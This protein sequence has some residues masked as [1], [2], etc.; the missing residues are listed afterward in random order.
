MR[1]S[2]N[3]VMI[4]LLTVMMVLG[5]GM[6][7]FRGSGKAY[8]A[9]AGDFSG[10]G[11]SGTPY[12]VGTA[13]QLNKIRGSYLG[14]GLY[15]KLN[16]DIDL[17]GYSHWAPIGD[18]N[19][20]FQGHMDG[21]GHTITGLT[22]NRPD[23]DYSGLFGYIDTDSTVSGMKLEQ[24]SVKGWQFTGGL[25]GYN[26]GGSISSSY[27][28]GNVSGMY[29]V[30]GLLGYNAGG[31]ID[32][33]HALGTVTG[34]DNSVQLG[35]LVGNSTGSAWE[36]SNSY[37]SV[38]VKGGRNS[39]EVGG[40]A[41]GVSDG[42]I[43]NSYALG[44]VSGGR[45]SKNVGGLVGVNDS[46][47]IISSYA[48]GHVSG[49][50][51]VGGLVGNE[52]TGEEITDSYATGNVSGEEHVGG[53]IGR[54]LRGTIRGG[55]ASGEV[56]GSNSSNL[57]GGL[58]GENLFGKIS[59]SQA[60]GA[61]LSGQGS[62]YVGGLTGRNE[63]AEI[64]NSP[65]SGEVN[66]FMYVGGLV[67]HDQ[68]GAISYSHASGHVKGEDG[69]LYIGGLVGYHQ[70]ALIS[71]SYALG[72]VSA[73]GDSFSIGGLVGDN[74][75]EI[76][77]SYASGKVSGAHF[78]GGLVGYTNDQPIST[79][80]ASGDVSGVEGVGGLVGYHMFNAISNSYASGKVSG[81]DGSTQVGG[82]I[83]ITAYGNIS[84]SYVSGKVS[85]SSNVGGFIGEDIYALTVNS[86]YDT[87]TT[88]QPGTGSGTGKVTA[89][90]QDQSTY[91][92]DMAH[93][94]DF[95][96]TWAI[97]ARHNG[98]Y[99]YL[100][101]IQAY[102]D[103]D[104]NKHTGGTAPANHSYMPGTKAGVYSGVLNI[105]KTGY[106][107]DGWNTQADGSGSSYRPGDLYTIT[108]DTTLYAKWKPV[109]T[110]ATLTSTIGTVSTGGTTNE[111]ITGIPYGTTL[112]SLKAAITTAADATFE[113]YEA[114]GTTVAT[115]LTSEQ[116]IIVTA[117]DGT[118][119][120]TYT[121]TVAASS[122]KEITAFSFAE[123]T[124]A[125][126]I[127]ATAHT[128]AVEVAYGTSLNGLVAAFSVSAG[129]LAKVGGVD[130]VSGVTA[131]DFTTPVV[132]VV[133]AA[134]GSTQSWTVTV[135][136][137]ASS[138][139]EITSFSFVEQTG[140][141]VIDAVA[142]TVAIEV[143]HGTSLNGLVATFSVSAGASVKVGGVD[144][145]SGSTANDFTAPVVYV[146]K[147]ADGS[148]QNWAVTVSVAA[149]SAKEITSFSFSEQTGAAVIDAGAQTVAIEVSHGTSLNG[150][151][152][153]F[154]V[155]AGATANV[156]GLDQVSGT[157]A[158][159]FT[160]PVIYVVQAA[161]GSTQSW[162][163]TVSVA[164]S[165]AKEITSFSLAEQT[166]AAVI[167]AFA[168]TVA[169]EVAHETS[170]NG[171]VSTFSVSTGALAKV[172]GVDQVSGTTANDF[173]APVVYVVKAADGSTQSWTVTVSVAASSAKEITS[174]SFVEQTG[175]AVIDAGTHTV[176]IEVA[177]GT[178]LNG[179]VSTFGVSAGASAKVGGV[180]QVSGSTANDFTTQVIYVVKAVDGSTQNWMVTVCV[181]A[182]SA[183]ELTVFSFAEQ[184]GAAVIDAVAHTVA[185]EV[186]H[187]TS[188]NGL[189]STFGLS[190]GASVK[191]G[192][193][194]Q[195]SGATANNFSAPV[196]Y[197]VKAA[198]GSTQNW[199][200]TVSIAA[201]SAKELTSFSFAQQTGAAVIDAVAHTVAIEVAHGTS[202]NSLVSTFSVSAGASAKVGGVDQVSGTTAND[203]T[204][205]VIY[206]VKAADGSMQNW[207]VTVSVA[208]SS[209]KELTAFSFAEQTGAAVIDATTHT[210]TIEVA[211]GTSLNGLVSTFSVSA[212]AS[213]KV[214]TVDQVSGTTANDFTAPVIYVVK[215]ADGST[216]NWTVTVSVA[217]SSSKKITSF[218]FAE[219]TGA[220]VIDA[221][222][223][224][225]AIEVVHGTSL[226]GLVSTFSVSAGASAKVGGVDQVSDTTSNDFTAPVVYVVKA[227]DGSIQNWTVTVSIAM[228][229]AKEIT[230]FSFAE[231]TGAAVIDAVAH[232]VAIE[233]VHGTSLNGLVSTFGLS[234]GASAKV[235]GVD[236]VSG[237]TANDFT[238]PVVYVVKAADGST[239]SW[240]VT[241]TTAAN[242]AKDLTAFSFQGLTPPI[243]GIINGTQIA[244]TVPNGTAVTSLV[245]TFTNSAG[246]TVTVG[247]I[248]QVSGTT[249]NDFTSPLT[250]TVTAQDGTRAS[251]TVVVTQSGVVGGS[252]SLSS[253][254][255][256]GGG[257]PLVADSVTGTTYQYKVSYAISSI[258]VTASAYD[259]HTRIVGSL[260]NSDHVLVTGPFQIT[261]GVGTDPIPL[262]VGGNRL[263]LVLTAVDGSSQT[264][265]VFVNRTSA[266]YSNAHLQSLQVGN[267]DLMFNRDILDYTLSVGNRV[268]T[269]TVK[270]LPEVTHAGVIIDAEPT[271]SKEI[272]LP[273]GSTII[274]I[275]VTAP[276]GITKR[277]YRVT[278]KRAIAITAVTDTSIPVTSDPVTITVPQGVTNAK[279]AVTPVVAGSNKE[280]I[281]PLIEVYAETAQGP[282]TVIIPEGTKVTAPEGWDGM[283]LLPEIQSNES[284]SVSGSRVSGV[285]EIG[286]PDVTLTFD[287]AIRLLFPKQGGKLAGYV[288]NGGVIPITASITSDTQATAD[289]EIAPG[290]E[291]KLT[292]GEDM[293]V[294]TK[295]FTK[296][297]FYLP[298]TPTNT[299]SSGGG[300]G[301]PSNTGIIYAPSGGTLTLNGVHIE[302]PAGAIE[303]DIQVTVD[304]LGDT[305]TMPTG[306][307]LSLVSD[308]FDIKKDTAG[309]FHK[310]VVLT[311]P[312]DKSKV[313][314]TK[315]TVGLY[316]WDEKKRT[317]LPLDDQ[318]VDQTTGKVSGTVRQFTKFAALASDKKV[319]TNPPTEVVDLGDIQ[320][321][322]A[323]TSIRELVKLGVIHGYSDRTFKPNNSITRAEFVTI[324][325]KAFQ[326]QAQTGQTFADTEAHWAR[327]AIE[328][329]A[330]LGVVTG[331][332]ASTFG[333]D[334]LITR[335][336]MAAIIIRAAHIDA[337]ENKGSF[338]DNADISDW[339]RT[340][341]ATAT[342]QALMNGYEDGT[343][344]PQANSTRA[345]AATVILRALQ[346]KKLW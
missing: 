181:A 265:L 75:G 273:V 302:V 343:V 12:L 321:H 269:L 51:R 146:V 2:G 70:N 141:A 246:S 67:G 322:W 26:N 80:F 333:P 227:A 164:A 318:Q 107:F 323:E 99:P 197:V 184:T 134:D 110:I 123:Q 266:A 52:S 50:T 169:I 101:A 81:D 142:H 161:N 57:V 103:Y 196:V 63:S 342:A 113:I 126:V 77:A 121:V 283:I 106:V 190:A 327:S 346:L 5:T 218:S 128:V 341:L 158:N 13:D 156:G 250:Y 172:G 64:S 262:A 199:T 139:K 124:G 315:S 207:T 193:V 68:D 145:V 299:G 133:K 241:V 58:V 149:S 93:R 295:H 326:L 288:S 91:E 213:A 29:N 194:D 125:A 252:P 198:D 290:G 130:Q 332:D 331:Y 89:E 54:N 78:V 191:V 36:I 284:I 203:F 276:D 298:V 53:L 309:E 166:G 66:G 258:S 109:S 140:A 316:G 279:I 240:T 115:V 212:G 144:Q 233:V 90:M 65:A 71:H 34:A 251:Y 310:S 216:Q 180:D 280:V 42:K 232:T 170:L 92:A 223:H 335:E 285:I 176:A 278:V 253:L 24:V 100:R 217:G 221:T 72:N 338:A 324:I 307:V 270:A 261:S 303:R 33:S 11:S 4:M 167:D 38:V 259:S 202:L 105:S 255:L 143:V 131:N 236:Q 249:A 254:M 201:S 8:A 151:V 247:S 225:V 245:A 96:N 275:E 9:G 69:G 205:P 85:G 204:A 239:Q 277:I 291:A 282:I 337:T 260:Y 189:V 138:A 27:A 97:D 208:A 88:G 178:S 16:G 188:L 330:S 22:I 104:G 257:V 345:E 83:G 177:H 274:P 220:A 320:G 137:A 84:N 319:T 116:K 98:G 148:T 281:L 308:I 243:V 127:D 339:A 311:L 209:A 135:S 292:L 119:K 94:W 17:S 238:A 185:I 6:G 74:H 294:W 264:Y 20:P 231:Q 165:S 18:D 120:V 289:R 329:A 300:G 159:D 328:V 215:A 21:N 214:G 1:S 317:W 312:Y 301:G 35:G 229:S 211:H 174:F 234:A 117:Q 306:L 296:Y 210:V 230:S 37:A 43:S 235:G 122:A 173:T 111:S 340:A 293:V 200:V 182:S 313:D 136:V 32:G 155:S 147:A 314:F 3:K 46:T 79:S 325:V 14:P 19:T 150:L 157:T 222:A 226:N 40:L 56:K 175:A 160:A 59:D 272:R 263:E 129:A 171:L 237:T 344:R 268:Q 118:T 82:L 15:F 48:S 192:G 73:G 228:S 86:F 179:L 336:Q 87:V 7:G 186:A 23:A 224:T 61:V 31:Q 45:R 39:T 219:Q 28:S 286:S 30:G 256:T 305:S 271:M 112:A 195:V 152:A 49:T 163:V 334:D 287:T 304:K 168:H 41:G 44:D 132:Y 244:L 206:V 102:L 10:D 76:Q 162:T 108:S 47:K 154:S 55:H 248:P 267:A 62:N 25:V 95:L 114:D 153:T 297:V 187:G 60:S 242:S 183:K